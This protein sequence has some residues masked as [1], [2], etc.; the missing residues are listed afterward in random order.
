MIG[1]SL[2]VW[3][4]QIQRIWNTKSKSNEFVQIVGSWL[5]HIPIIFLTGV[6]KTDFFTATATV[7][8]QHLLIKSN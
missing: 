7:M 1:A 4:I 5:H 6:N 3:Q 2:I 8:K